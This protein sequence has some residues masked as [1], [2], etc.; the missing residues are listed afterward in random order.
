[1]LRSKQH[2]RNKNK[3]THQDMLKPKSKFNPHNKDVA[4]E[5]CLSGLEEKLMHIQVAKDKFKNLTNGEQKVLFA[6]KSY[7]RIVIKT[8]DK[9]SVVVVWERQDYIKDVEKQ[10]GHEEVY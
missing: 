2:F 7:K 8:T 5:L 9:G 4:I 10:L 1:M 6:L 3:D